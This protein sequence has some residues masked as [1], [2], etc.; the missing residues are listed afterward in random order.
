MRILRLITLGLVLAFCL[1]GCNRTQPLP[2]PVRPALV[3]EVRQSTDLDRRIYSGEVRARYEAGLSFRAP[4]KLVA[5]YVEVG[6]VVKA[7]D[8]LARLDPTDSALGAKAAQAQ[9][10]AALADYTFARN[11]LERYSVLLEKKFISQTIYDAK[12]YAFNAA[13]ARHEQARSQAA[14]AGNQAGYA[15]LQADQAGVITAILADPGQVL[16]VGQP[17]MKLARLEEKEVVVAIPESRLEEL[18]ALPEV[19]IRL[20]AHP[21]K[22]YP[23]K[24]REIAPNADA[25]TRTFAVRVSVLEAGP[26]VNLG[27]TANVFLAGNATPAVLLP[28]SA[29]TQKDGQA[30]VWVVEGTENK[31]SPRQV[32][33]VKYGDDGVWISSGLTAGERVVAAGVHKLLPGQQVLPLLQPATPTAKP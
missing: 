33:V 6:S 4:G 29:V 7:G 21:D 9:A 8:V 1:A 22:I 20:L 14:V 2:D 26:E 16:G 18:S 10:A 23:G 3:I 32:K 19:S 27:M 24:V 31:V 5:R 11:E 12:Q 25:A 15:T 13:K 17:V 30:L 28:L